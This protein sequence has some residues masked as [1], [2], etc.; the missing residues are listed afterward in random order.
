MYKLVKIND[1]TATR[2]VELE[3]EITGHIDVCFDDSALVST[4]NFEFMK[5]GNS[6]NCFI[7]LFGTMV[8]EGDTEAV[9]CKIISDEVVGYKEFLKVLVDEEVYYIPK[10][11]VKDKTKDEFIFAYTRK[12]LI[13]VDKVVH[14]DL[15]SE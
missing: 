2:T 9:R 6:Y 3:N 12:D 11:K 8:N 7:K 4:K 1:S 14:D 13:K 15:L 5:V 10:N